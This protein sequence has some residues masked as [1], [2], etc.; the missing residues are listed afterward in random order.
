MKKRL[1]SGLTTALFILPGWGQ[2]QFSSVLPRQLATPQ[3]T[4][5]IIQPSGLT[6][7]SRVGTPAIIPRQAGFQ[8]VDATYRHKNRFLIP[9]NLG[10]IQSVRVS[11]TIQAFRSGIQTTS[12]AGASHNHSIPSLSVNGV[13]SSGSSTTHNHVLSVATGSNTNTLSFNAGQIQASGAGGSQSVGLNSADHT[14]SVTGGTTVSNTAGSESSHTHNLNNPTGLYET[15]MAQGVH[16]FIDGVDQTTPLSGPWGVGSAID[17]S[18]LDI[19]S[20][21]TSTGWHEV[22]LSSTTIGAITS[23]V[24]IFGLLRSL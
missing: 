22:Q 7:D 8:S 18:E 21:V 24:D 20:F 6:Y 5:L 1:I 2:Q 12:A 15:G 13:T 23:N 10:V 16:L 11:F 19:T 3:H 14:H 17:I 9:T 4:G